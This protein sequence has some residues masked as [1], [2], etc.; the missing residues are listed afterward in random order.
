MEKKKSFTLRYAQSVTEQVVHSDIKNVAQNSGLTEEEVES[1]VMCCSNF[2]FP[3]EL[4]HLRRLGIDEISLVK[5]QGKFIVV[6]VDLDSHKLIGL[7]PERKQSEIERTMLNWGEKILEQIEEVSMDMT[8]NYKHLINKICP[9]A[10]VTVDRF[11]VAKMV[12]E[13]LNQARIA[14]K[15]TAQSLELKERTKLFDGLKGSKYTL[16]KSESQLSIQQQER[17]KQ[18]KEASP[19]LGIMHDLKEEFNQ[20]FE[21]NT[22]VGQGVLELI[23][24]LKKSEPY[25]KKSVKTIQRWLG[26]IVGYFEQRTTNGIVEGINNKLNLLKRCGFGFR[27]FHNFHIRALLLWHFPN[28]LAQ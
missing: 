15:Q 17:L 26:E 12:H 14:Q 13:E 11:H 23:D 24:W 3:L 25:Y 27:N 9:N 8:G 18:V 4:S 22:E 5:G 1:M 28:I 2:L 6:L 7:V 10:D 21:R 20:L 16:L 19:L